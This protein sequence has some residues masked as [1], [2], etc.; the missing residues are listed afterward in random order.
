MRKGIAILFSFICLPCLAQ[1][2]LTKKADAILIQAKVYSVMDKVQI[3]PSGD[4]HDYMS[5]G[6][7]W[8][9]DTTKKRWQ[10]LCSP[11]WRTKPG[12]RFDFRFRRDG[13]DDGGCGYSDPSLPTNQRGKICCL[14]DPF[15]RHLVYFPCHQTDA[16]FEFR[17][18]HPGHQY[19]SGNRHHR[20]T[21]FV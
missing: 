6:P 5:Q 13:L 17:T 19:W 4:K 1:S 21:P 3:P 18:R 7:Y 11:G 15:N 10:T 9:P 20:N 16:S 14:G 12:N 2:E 8:W